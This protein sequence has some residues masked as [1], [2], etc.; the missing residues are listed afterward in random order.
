[1]PATLAD[2]EVDDQRDRL[3]AEFGAD[4]PQPLLVA[5][6]QHD[7]RA[8]V[9]QRPGAFEADARGRAGDRR[10]FSKQILSHSNPLR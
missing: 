3:R 5:V 7:P 6:D 8:G 1:M 2:G 9:D 10:D 4:A